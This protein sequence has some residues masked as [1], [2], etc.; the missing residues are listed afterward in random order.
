MGYRL[1]NKEVDLSGIRKLTYVPTTRAGDVY[2]YKNM[3]LRIFKDGEKVIDQE[4]AK[5][6]TDISTERILLPKKLL[7]YNSA[8]KGYTMKLVSQK[9]SGKKLITTPTRDLINC[10]EVLEKDIETLSQKRVLLNDINPGYTLYNGELFLVNP[11]NYST[12]DLGDAK[13]LEQL[14]AFQ[15]HLLLTELFAGELRKEK[16]PTP[17]INELKTML[18]LRD[19]DE[20]ISSYLK[21]L[22]NGQPNVKE[23]VKKIR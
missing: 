16:C 8:F 3:A 21:E 1:D 11:A 18:N 10:V 13:T 15:L 4:T 7:F 9:G 22:M 12:L 2:R 20:R 6:L 17:A 14:N 23:L 19:N 5:Y